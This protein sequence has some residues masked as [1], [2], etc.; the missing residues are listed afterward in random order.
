MGPCSV[1]AGG[2]G[3]RGWREVDV[4]KRYIGGRVKGLSGYWK[5]MFIREV[6]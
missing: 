4:I 6:P 5:S 1:Q 2:D 3:G